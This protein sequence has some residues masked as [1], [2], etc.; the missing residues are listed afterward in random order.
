MGALGEGSRWVRE[1]GGGMVTE[2]GP[3]T[4]EARLLAL[5]MEG[6]RGPSHPGSVGAGKDRAPVLP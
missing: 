2:A 5:R 3:L 1:G 4:E 6:G